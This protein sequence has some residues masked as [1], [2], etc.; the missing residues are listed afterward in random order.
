MPRERAWAIGPSLTVP[1]SRVIRRVAPLSISL[2]M[3]V[4]LGP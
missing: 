2:S 1:Q 4:M 3:A